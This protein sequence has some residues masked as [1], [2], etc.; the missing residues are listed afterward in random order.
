[1]TQKVSLL[2]KK[3][4]IGLI[5]EEELTLERRNVEIEGREKSSFLS[6]FFLRSVHSTRLPNKTDEK[7]DLRN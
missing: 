3:I 2:T 7:F 6:S 4:R 5:G 1:M